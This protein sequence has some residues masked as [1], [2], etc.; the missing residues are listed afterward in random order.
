MQISDKGIEFLKTMEGCIKINDIHIIYDDKN[1]KPVN[2]NEPLPNGA[3]IG[4]GHLIKPNEDFRNGITE[5]EAI[6]LLKQD[7]STTELF[8]KNNITT[9]LNQNQYDALVSLVYNIGA[10]NFINSSVIKYINN[11]NFYN[12]KYPDLEHAWK[13]WNQYRGKQIQGLINRRNKEWNLY[14]NCIY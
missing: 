4:Y 9:I 6:N 8:I 13:A 5:S 12:Q 7:I 11:R 14:K 3:T 1:G 2:L 10:K